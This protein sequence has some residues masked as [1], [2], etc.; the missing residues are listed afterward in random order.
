MTILMKHQHRTNVIKIFCFLF[1]LILLISGTAFAS[2]K[3]TH[4]NIIVLYSFTKDMP[5]NIL[6]DNGMEK[7]F[8][9]CEKWQIELYKEYMDS[10]RFSDKKYSDQLS[11]L[12]RF[13]YNYRK[14]DL[15]IV[16]M[17]P[18]L[19][20]ILQNANE[21]FPDVPIIF[22]TVEKHRLQERRINKNM[23]GVLYQLD[24]KKSI[25]AAL[26]LQP[27]TK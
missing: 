22:C 7:I 20:F 13:K 21:I 6:I 1:L 25:E 23:T 19:D 15:I 5:A 24:F 2:N 16:V 17:V 26:T 27:K 14:M 8:Q 4:K 11:G 12:L 18:A 9:A 3:E 10:A